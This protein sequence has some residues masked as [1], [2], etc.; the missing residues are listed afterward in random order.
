[1]NRNDIQTRLAGRRIN[2]LLFLL[3][4]FGSTFNLDAGSPYDA[5][6]A[7]DLRNSP[8][9]AL[10]DVI[11]QFRSTPANSDIADLAARGAKLKMRFKNVPAAL[12]SLPPAALSAI[13]S[14]PFVRYVSP[15]RRIAGSLEY[16]APTVG[17]DIA[18]Q[19]GWTGSG[20]GVAIVDSGVAGDHPDLKSRI[21]YSQNFVTREARSDDPYGHGTHV[22]GIVAGNAAAS[23]G[24]SYTRTFR[25]LA[26]QAQIVNLRVLDSNG[27]GVDSAVINAIDRAIELKATYNIRVL[28]LSLG[29][30]IR[31]SYTLDPLCQAVRG[32]WQAGLVVVVAAGNNGRDDSMGTK[33][34]ATITSPANTP[35]A[36]TVG[37]MRDM[38]TTVPQRRSDC[39]LQ[40]ERPDP[41]RSRRQARSCSSG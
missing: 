5:K 35:E 28:N 29:R 9:G 41:Y 24:P 40:F 6:L 15:D 17:G 18:F 27:Q 14:L 7:P 1:M 10:A 22:A 19:S 8:A 23:Y 36:I 37:A 39:K 2:V 21:V 25:G 3:T 4:L 13:A 11:V 31:E 33:G 32:A 26:P 20:V 30:T 12:V 16:A 34:Y 38:A